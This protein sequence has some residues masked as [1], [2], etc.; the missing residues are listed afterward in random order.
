M[1]NLTWRAEFFYFIKEKNKVC[2][3][4]YI[5]YISTMAITCNWYRANDSRNVASVLHLAGGSTSSSG[6][7]P[8]QT[9]LVFAVSLN[10][11]ANCRRECIIWFR[12]FHPRY[13]QM[14]MSVFE[15]ECVSVYMLTIS[16][17]WC[18]ATSTCN[19]AFGTVIGVV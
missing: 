15:R 13:L 2:L 18:N 10:V 12:C 7:L 14:Q 1:V 6:N 16:K 17:C 8:D 9:M 11:T 3:R 19:L 5:I 4:N